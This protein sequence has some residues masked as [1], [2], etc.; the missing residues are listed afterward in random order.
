MFG[1]GNITEME[2]PEEDCDATDEEADKFV[3]VVTV[4]AATFHWPGKDSFTL[5]V[6]QLHIPKGKQISN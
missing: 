3:P 4:D 5:S 2:E 1:L 6:P